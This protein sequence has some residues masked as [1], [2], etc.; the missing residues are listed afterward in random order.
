MKTPFICKIC[1][2]ATD[3]KNDLI[4][5]AT[6]DIYWGESADALN[7]TLESPFFRKIFAEAPRAPQGKADLDNRDLALYGG[8]FLMIY[9]AVILL[10]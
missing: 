7:Y 8:A 4:F 9:I 5:C 2:S 6:C 10:T 3:L 1:D